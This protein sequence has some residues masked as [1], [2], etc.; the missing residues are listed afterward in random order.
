MELYRWIA[1]QPRGATARLVRESG[2]SHETIRQ[3][4]NGHPLVDEG[5][6]QAISDA[7][8]GEVSRAELLSPR[9]KR[10]A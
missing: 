5:K 1:S 4:K 3:L 6:A 2:V 9:K 10:V 8:G 7:T